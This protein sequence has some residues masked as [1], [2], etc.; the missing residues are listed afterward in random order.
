MFAIKR[1]STFI[2]RR[3]LVAKVATMATAIGLISSAAVGV[4][5]V[6]TKTDASAHDRNNVAT[7]QALTTTNTNYAASQH[8]KTN[9][10]KVLVDGK[11]VED[12]SF[13]TSFVKTYAFADQYVAH[14]WNVQVTAWDSS[15]YSYT[16]SGTSTPCVPPVTKDASASASVGTAATCL[17]DSTV[18]FAITNATWDTDADLTVGSHTRT[19]TA[20][21]KHVFAD[22]STKATVT[23]V[24]TAKLPAQSTNPQG[25]CY[26]PPPAVKDADA[27]VS[28]GTNATC[29]ATSTPSFTIE[30]ASWNEDV[31]STVG[32]HTRTATADEGH[33]FAD[34][35][36]TKTV[37]YTID[38]QL[39]SQSTNPDGDCYTPPPAVKDAT[40]SASAGSVETCT[41]GSTTSF[42]IEHA[43]WN[44]DVDTTVGTHTRTATADEGHLFAD[45]SK[46]ATVEYTVKDKL[47]S[48]STDKDGPC[49][50][51]PP[52]EHTTPASFTLQ[53]GCLAGEDSVTAP[54][55]P[56]TSDNPN[57]LF[58]STV[59]EGTYYWNA[60]FNKD[61]S[62]KSFDGGIFVP[63][64]GYVLNEPGTGD[65]YKLVDGT[66]IWGSYPFNTEPC[67]TETP[68]PTPT[69]SVTPT[70]VHT[71]SATPTPSKSPVP[72]VV[73][74][75]NG[76]PPKGGTL[77]FTGPTVPIASGTGIALLLLLAGAG[78]LVVRRRKASEA[79]VSG[80]NQ[81]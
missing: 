47:P 58:A 65:T 50:V 72:A 79:V 6:T 62:Y 45:G 49:Y 7:C 25:E 29:T 32:T 66:A 74:P 78:V 64:D 23:Y 13:S 33:L 12:T 30:H 27:S 16:Q 40:A 75:H 43:S 59:K 70:P 55:Q 10:I 11:V 24:I 3:S 14:T 48:Q 52:K 67:A 71:P 35:S 9:K 76:T 54:G 53:D 31:D 61:K 21:A 63:N 77:A 36:S 18:N 22:G 69:P 20:D 38:A 42:A 81:E 17:A 37:S 5:A 46:T 80:A 60:T 28:T 19:A 57:Y 15:G 8:G 2:K 73:V 68:K 41:A 51:A 26:T 39:P 44:E 1:R 56:T 34:G 4:Q